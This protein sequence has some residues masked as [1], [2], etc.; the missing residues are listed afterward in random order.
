MRALYNMA[1]F[2]FTHWADISG[3]LRVI[4]AYQALLNVRW[5]GFTE[6]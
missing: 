2:L 5:G 1:V 4:G 3:F 6:L